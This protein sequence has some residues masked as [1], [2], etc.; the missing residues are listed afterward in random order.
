[1]PAVHVQTFADEGVKALHGKGAKAW[2]LAEA[3]MANLVI[4]GTC[5]THALSM[6]HLFANGCV[7]VAKVSGHPCSKRY[8]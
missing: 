8:S 1:M 7:F 6:K 5:S 3:A 4:D 2:R